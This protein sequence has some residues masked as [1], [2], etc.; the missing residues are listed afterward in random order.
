M[1]R[2]LG[3]IYNVRVY[4]GVGHAVVINIHFKPFERLI[5]HLNI[6]RESF[7][8]VGGTK[9]YNQAIKREWIKVQQPNS[10]CTEVT[11]SY[12]HYCTKI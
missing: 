9:W 10:F 1:T 11:P 7:L 12:P 2:I 8:I 6:L 5:L 4:N 3:V